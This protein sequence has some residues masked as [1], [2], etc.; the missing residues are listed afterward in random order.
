MIGR[1]VTAIVLLPLLLL[2]P[3][4]GA[5]EP[6]P[7]DRNLPPHITRLTWFGER[8]DFSPDGQRVLFLSKTFG[9]VMEVEIATGII[10]NLT[11]RY[12]HHG[13]VRALYLANGDILVTGPVAFDPDQPGRARNESWM[14]VLDPESGEPPHPLGVKC[15]EGP[16]VSRTRMHVAWSYRAVQ[17]PDQMAPGSSQIHEGD[18]VY[19]DGVPRLVN[20]RKLLDSEDFPFHVMLEPQ[21]FRPPD[22]RELIFSAYDYQGTEVFGVDLQTGEWRNYSNAPG[23]YAEPE[24]IFPSGDY[25]TVE[26]DLHDPQGY[27]RAD[28]YRLALDG[29]GR[30]ERLTH[31]ADVPTYRSS[32]P[33]ISDDGRYMAFQMGRARVAAG[34]G[35]GIFLYDFRKVAGGG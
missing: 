11:A 26:S 32:N 15:A 3:A 17:V 14:F 6:V 19:V 4:A 7:P 1:A 29:S 8:A 9:D 28:I 20:R 13:Y 2:S 16:A 35:Y 31:F 5:Q 30:M 22:E 18:V 10:R 23:V 27:D 34:T 21:N 12:P 25:T 24:G 33:V